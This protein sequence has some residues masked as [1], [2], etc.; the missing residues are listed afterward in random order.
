MPIPYFPT[1]KDGRHVKRVNEFKVLKVLRLFGHLRRQEIAAAVWPASSG[2]SG[3]IMACRT[4]K[5]LLEQELILK[6]K[7]TLATDSFV[8]A[9]K[10]VSALHLEEELIAQE[11]YT[12]AFDGPQFFHRTLGTTY[13]LEKARS[14]HEVFGE[15]AVIKGLAP[16]TREFLRGKFKKIPDGLVVYSS[17]L[18]GYKEGFRAADWVEV[19]SAYKNYDE[20]E[21]ILALLTKNSELTAK[22]NLVI[23][24]LVFVYDSRQKH[25][26]FILRAAKQFL[27]TTPVWCLKRS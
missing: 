21:K 6:R 26:R 1:R 23:N 10:G 19:E 18:M 11:G 4:I 9:S 22:G 12:L 14:G 20:L 7:N 3:Y 25:D 2:P 5:A 24:K 15:Y 27:K 8:L 17:Q 13:L 16:V